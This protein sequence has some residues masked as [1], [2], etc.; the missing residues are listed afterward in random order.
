MLQSLVWLNFDWLLLL[1]SGGEVQG[2]KDLISTRAVICS[3]R[4]RRKM[5]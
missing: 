4:M 1:Y 5:W 2:R 3:S